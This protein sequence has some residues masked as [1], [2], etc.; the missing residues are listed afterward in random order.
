VRSYRQYCSLAKALD[1]VGDRWTLLVVRELLLR[2]SARYTDLRDGLPG[3]ATNLLAE[4]LRELEEAGLVVREQAPPPVATTLY[5]LTP[6]G[7]ELKVAVHALARWGAPLMVDDP[8]DDAFRGHWLAFPAEILLTDRTPDRAP[9][10]LEVRAGD[11]PVVLETG[12]GGVRL[13]PGPAERPDAVM[14]GEPRLVLGTLMGKLG[15]D[16]ARERGLSYDG[17]P[18]VLGRLR[19][20]S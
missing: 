7:E 2:G 14:S 8:G 12:D 4:R 3:I 9:V 15:L 5:R 13:R 16:E 18:R 11:A 1:V 6:R 20:A 19:P 10:A 17:D